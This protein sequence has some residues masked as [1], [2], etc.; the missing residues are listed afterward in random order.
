MREAAMSQCGRRILQ[1][2]LCAI[3]AVAQ[4]GLTGPQHLYW[5]VEDVFTVGVGTEAVMF[6]EVASM[7]FGAPGELVVLDS[8]NAEFLVLNS[9]SGAEIRRVGRRGQGPGE[10]IKPRHIAVR[11]DGTVYVFDAASGWRLS[12]FD[13]DGKFRESEQV[14]A[15]GTTTGMVSSVG[16]VLWARRPFPVRI[17]GRPETAAWPQLVFRPSEGSERVVWDWTTLTVKPR[18]LGSPLSINLFAARPIWGLVSDTRVAAARTDQYDIAILD[19]EGNEVGHLSREIEP[20]K[21]T[22]A[23]REK[24]LAPLRRLGIGLALNFPDAD[25]FPLL[26]GFFPGPEHT[27]LIARRAGGDG[28]MFDIFSHEGE[29]LG[30]V[31]VP[32]G[33]TPMAARGGLVAGTQPTADLEISV[34]VIRIRSSNVGPDPNHTVSSRYR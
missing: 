15:M 32:S 8:S 2:V 14:E 1:S 10:F 25:F 19:L 3:G 6:G 33:F 22:A 24:A 9:S 30:G 27:I 29:H 11:N 13:A 4:L 16:G 12:T 7:A 21:I 28:A 31:A 34:R 23:L 26:I 20:E 17:P 5:D 18:T